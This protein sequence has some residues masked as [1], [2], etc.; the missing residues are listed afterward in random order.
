M[1]LWSK[2]RKVEKSVNLK[3]LRARWLPH[4]PH[5]RRT[6]AYI[7]RKVS[8]GG[9]FETNPSSVSCLPLLRYKREEGTRDGRWK[10]KERRRRKDERAGEREG[11]Q[12]TIMAGKLYQDEG[13]EEE[14]NRQIDRRRG[15]L[16][17]WQAFEKAIWRKIWASWR[18]LARQ[19]E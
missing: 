9:F 6:C 10:G 11:V 18:K 2:G 19:R 7:R 13:K 14:W 17:D 16:R 12:V 8:R 3:V 5:L 4:K 15:W 1:I